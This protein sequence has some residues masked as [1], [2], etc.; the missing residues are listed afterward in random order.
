MSLSFCVSGSVSLTMETFSLFPSHSLAVCIRQYSIIFILPCVLHFILCQFYYDIIHRPL[1]AKEEK[2]HLQ[3]TRSSCS[4]YVHIRVD[5]Y[6][7][8][9]GH[10]G[11]ADKA[12]ATFAIA[13]SF[14]LSS[15][16]LSLSFSLPFPLHCLLTHLPFFQAQR[17]GATIIPSSFQYK[18][19]IW[20]LEIPTCKCFE[21]HIQWLPYVQIWKMRL[22]VIILSLSPLSLLSLSPLLSHLCAFSRSLA[23][24][25][26]L[27]SLPSAHVHSPRHPPKQSWPPI[28]SLN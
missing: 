15:S 1:P 17:T 21:L 6:N 3:S 24:S 16:L 26:L 23:R 28:A 19:F 2:G 5:S 20:I 12:A 8:V 7:R 14:S 22:T 25:S 9:T 10:E 11:N 27:F 18:L 13:L 4:T